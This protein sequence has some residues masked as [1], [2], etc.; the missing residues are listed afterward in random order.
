MPNYIRTR[1][2]GGTYFF[3]LV[4]AQRRPVFRSPV[5]VDCLRRA[6]RHI[7]RQYPFTTEAIVIL[8]DHLHVLWTLP[9]GD[10]DYPLRLQL[11][12]SRATRELRCVGVRD[13]VWQRRY[14]EHYVRDGNDFRRHMDYIAYNPVKHGLVSV[15]WYWPHGSFRRLVSL[16][17]YPRSW[18]SSEPLTTRGMELE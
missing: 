15:P 17:Y 5:A 10:A 9:D 16:G 11:L 7:A 13:A 12:K 18:G 2:T 14:W 6:Y 1:A 4:T 8:P 3:T